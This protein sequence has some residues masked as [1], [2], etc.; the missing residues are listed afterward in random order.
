ML[1]SEPKLVIIRDSETFL[2]KKFP[3]Y[4]SRILKQLPTRHHSVARLDFYQTIHQLSCM[5]FT[6]CL[7]LLR[8]QKTL[9]EL[10][11]NFLQEELSDLLK[12]EPNNLK[13]QLTSIM[14]QLANLSK[15]N[16]VKTRLANAK[17][18]AML[19]LAQNV[20]SS[21]T[22]KQKLDQSIA[23]LKLKLE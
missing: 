5:R 9:V 12:N 21:S 17:K 10:D 8:K 6:L 13:Q 7:D 18:D 11:I 16:A 1:L 23:F 4:A 22:L 15:T 3:G 2:V 20:E 19:S 14:L